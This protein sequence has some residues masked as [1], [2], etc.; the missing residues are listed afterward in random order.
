MLLHDFIGDPDGITSSAVIMALAEIDPNEPLVVRINSDGGLV[1]HGT[2]IYNA[3]R[4][5]PGLVHV[6]IDG[7]AASMASIIAMA[8][9]TITIG[10]AATVMIH[11]AWTIT[12]GD[13]RD[14]KQAADQLETITQQMAEIYANRTDNPVARVREWMDAETVFSAKG[15]VAAGFADAVAK[16]AAKN[17]NLR[18]AATMGN[19]AL[20][21]QMR[22]NRL[23]LAMKGGQR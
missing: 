7:T 9:D 11:N 17:Q 5:R 23:Q 1:S 16:P 14:H 2:A 12:L 21:D 8:G 10:E 22:R 18:T 19:R 6:S 20:D 3:L 4:A 15:A 13:M